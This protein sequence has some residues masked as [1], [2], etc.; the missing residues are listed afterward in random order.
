MKK[1]NEIIQKRVYNDESK[2]YKKYKIYKIYKIIINN[3]YN[4]KVI[5][6][7]YV[8]LFYILSHIFWISAFVI[9]NI[10]YI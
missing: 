9:T 6:I 5:L 4:N 3:K 10:Y 7:L 1:K 2:I 8:T